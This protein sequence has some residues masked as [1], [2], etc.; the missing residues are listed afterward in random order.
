MLTYL[1]TGSLITEE[2][3]MCWGWGSLRLLQSYMHMTLH[4]TEVQVGTV[5]PE[6]NIVNVRLHINSVKTLK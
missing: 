2:Q 1:I 5:E 6:R 4:Q 3:D